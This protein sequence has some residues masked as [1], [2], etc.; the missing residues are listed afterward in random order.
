MLILLLGTFCYNAY[1]DNLL[2]SEVSFK[3]TFSVLDTIAHNESIWDAK[4]GALRNQN[5]LQLHSVTLSLSTARND[6]STF[7]LH[8]SFLINLI[9]LISTINF[10][11]VSLYVLPLY[12]F[13]RNKYIKV[14]SIQFWKNGFKYIKQMHAKASIHTNW[15]VESVS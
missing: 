12:Y 8:P 6:K 1:S 2:I 5:Q 10:Y 3:N 9:K 13:Y 14:C 4:V 7:F 11:Y 15:R